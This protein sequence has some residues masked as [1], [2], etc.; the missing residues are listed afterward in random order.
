MRHSLE[1]CLSQIRSYLRVSL[2]ANRLAVCSERFWSARLEGGREKQQEECSINRLVFG[3]VG[4]LV[5]AGKGR[6]AAGWVRKIRR[7][8]PPRSQQLLLST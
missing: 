8:M 1:T 7:R 6:V 5:G 3:S 4:I 2:V